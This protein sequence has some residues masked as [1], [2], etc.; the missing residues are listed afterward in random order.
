[1]TEGGP[2]VPAARDTRCPP[3]DNQPGAGVRAHTDV[4]RAGGQHGGASY[5]LIHFHST[6]STLDSTCSLGEEGQ[7]QLKHPNPT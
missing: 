5:S 7:V 2:C 1:M 6:I 3:G 4:G